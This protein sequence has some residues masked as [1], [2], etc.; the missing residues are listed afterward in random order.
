MGWNAAGRRHISG[1]LG[2]IPQPL[3]AGR[4]RMKSGA[5][6]GSI[7][8]HTAMVHIVA[9]GLALSCIRWVCVAHVLV[10]DMLT[11]RMELMP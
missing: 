11:L 10:F 3:L 6:S 9:R 1:E 8:D 2:R 7:L 5:W 4:L